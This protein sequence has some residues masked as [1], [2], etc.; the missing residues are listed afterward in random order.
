MPGSL[1]ASQLAT[2]EPLG[3]DEVHVPVDISQDPA[4]L[5]DRIVGELD[6]LHGQSAAVESRA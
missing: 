4:S 6:V 1:L 5:V 3:S 2:L